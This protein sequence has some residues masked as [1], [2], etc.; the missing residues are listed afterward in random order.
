[1]LFLVVPPVRSLG[2]IVQV[3]LERVEQIL[4]TRCQA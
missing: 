2:S 1:M 4:V 3:R